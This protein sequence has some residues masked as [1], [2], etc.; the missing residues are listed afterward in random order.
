MKLALNKCVN[1]PRDGEWPA[2]SE[3]KKQ[4][5]TLKVPLAAVKKEILHVSKALKSQRKKYH[6]TKIPNKDN[7]KKDRNKKEQGKGT[8]DSWTWKKMLS[9]EEDPNTKKKEGK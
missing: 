2:P 9:L 3:E 5:V 6:Q 7:R 4:I 1:K 8:D